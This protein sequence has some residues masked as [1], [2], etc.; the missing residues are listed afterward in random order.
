[1]SIPNKIQLG[2][3]ITIGMSAYNKPKVTYKAL[4]A[5]FSS[6]EGD[7]ELILVDDCSS[8]DIRTI[9]LQVKKKLFLVGP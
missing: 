9:F 4:K 5:L 6:A 8:D 2:S 7:F 3:N 1:M